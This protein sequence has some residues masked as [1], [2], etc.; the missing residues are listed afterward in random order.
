MPDAV[1]LLKVWLTDCLPASSGSRTMSI[2][3][4]RQMHEHRLL[5]AGL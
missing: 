2:D 5:E 1:S 4:W 3:F